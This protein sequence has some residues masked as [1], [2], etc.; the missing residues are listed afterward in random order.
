MSIVKYFFAFLAHVNRIYTI[1]HNFSLNNLPIAFFDI[2][3]SCALLEFFE[4]A[5]WFYLL[6]YLGN[7]AD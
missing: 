4:F 3:Q 5:G 1:N 2:C 6:F 7:A